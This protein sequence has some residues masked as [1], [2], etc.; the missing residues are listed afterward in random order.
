MKITGKRNQDHFEIQE[1]KTLQPSFTDAPCLKPP[2]KFLYRKPESTLPPQPL[3][4]QN[5][6]IDN[7][8]ELASIITVLN[9]ETGLK[10][11]KINVFFH[12][13]CPKTPKSL[14]DR[15]TNLAGGLGLKRRVINTGPSLQAPKRASLKAPQTLGL[16]SRGPPS[17]GGQKK[18]SPCFLSPDTCLGLSPFQP[19]CSGE[20]AVAKSRSCSFSEQ[21]RVFEVQTRLPHRVQKITGIKVC[22]KKRK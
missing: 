15:R 19:G 3:G 13:R 7:N 20:G 17:Q 1:F 2:M 11:S 12:N 14:L 5:Q 21:R 16:F 9:S 10:S 4:D 6:E 18:E 22:T 8:Q